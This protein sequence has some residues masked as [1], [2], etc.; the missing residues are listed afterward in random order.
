MNKDLRSRARVPF[1]Y[2]I[3][4]GFAVIDPEE[5]KTFIVDYETPE[6]Y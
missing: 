3:V 5:A 2:K 4:D 1:G 6:A